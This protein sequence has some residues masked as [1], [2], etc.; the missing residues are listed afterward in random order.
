MFCVCH[1]LQLS[2]LSV[3]KLGKTLLYIAFRSHDLP[4]TN[5]SQPEVM[6]HQVG[7]S[8]DKRLAILI[9]HPQWQAIHQWL[10]WHQVTW[11]PVTNGFS[12]GMPCK[13]C[14]TELKNK[15]TGQ[16]S[17][18]MADHSSTWSNMNQHEAM[19]LMNQWSSHNDNNFVGFK[20]LHSPLQKRSVS[21]HHYQNQVTI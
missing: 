21:S 15:M 17:N 19:I 8:C 5:E 6:W 14:S 20:L 13:Q 4:S 9:W 10:M 18:K 11:Q 3:Y 2:I 12:P 7:K 1:H 16:P